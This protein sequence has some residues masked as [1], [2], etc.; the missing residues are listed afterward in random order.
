MAAAVAVA[1]VAVAASSAAAGGRHP[2]SFR[3]QVEQAPLLYTQN[4]FLEEKSRE[5]L[6]KRP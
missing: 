4:S 3:P 2:C 1:V 6:A 5:K